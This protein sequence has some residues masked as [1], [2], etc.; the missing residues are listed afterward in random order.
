L[1]ERQGIGGAGGKE[2]AEF[3]ARVQ[4]GEPGGEFSGGLAVEADAA[5]ARRFLEEGGKTVRLAGADVGI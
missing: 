1:R 5:K 3:E 4:G 2:E